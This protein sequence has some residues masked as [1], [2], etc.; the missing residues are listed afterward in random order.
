MEG[1]SASQAEAAT[2]PPPRRLGGRGCARRRR[3][4]R[5][6]GRGG[7]P[8]G[9]PNRPQPGEGRREP[10]SAHGVYATDVGGGGRGPGAAGWRGGARREARPPRPGPPG[11]PRDPARP[12]PPRPIGFLCTTVIGAKRLF[13]CSPDFQAAGISFSRCTPTSS[14]GTL[15]LQETTAAAP[16]TVF[17]RPGQP[18]S[19]LEAATRL[20]PPPRRQS[21]CWE[22]G[23]VARE[24]ASR[25]CLC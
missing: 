1:V 6:R 19:L 9:R 4:R 20:G 14:N 7:L 3:R 24:I 16:C 12:P 23:S 5:R 17:P 15:R 11:S 21:W 18:S 25:R 13:K 22:G 10:V 2:A 8:R